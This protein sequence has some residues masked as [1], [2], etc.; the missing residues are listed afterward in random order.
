MAVVFFSDFLIKY[1]LTYPAL[2]T[3]F[4][5]GLATLAAL[6]RYRTS[7]KVSHKILLGVLLIISTAIVSF[8]IVLSIFFGV[9]HRNYKKHHPEGPTPY[10]VE[11]MQQ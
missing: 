7:L 8:A 4:I 9:A 1:V 6:I 2:T 3:I 5:V 11:D 10:I